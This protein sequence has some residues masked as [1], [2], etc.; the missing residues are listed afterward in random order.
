MRKNRECEKAGLGVASEWRGAGAGPNQALALRSGARRVRYQ[1]SFMLKAF[2]IVTVRWSS[3][4]P[5]RA[6][7][8]VCT[9]STSA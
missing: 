2:F 3:T 6:R 4:V 1:W 8:C 9:L 7:V 5:S